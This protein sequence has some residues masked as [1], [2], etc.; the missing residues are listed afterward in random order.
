MARDVG[1]DIYYIATGGKVPLKWTAPEVCILYK[2]IIVRV[3]Y[4]QYITKNF[5]HKVMCGVLDVYCMKY[6]VWA[7]NHLKILMEKR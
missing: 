1:D 6:G 2:Q 4:R 3:S 7:I 5:Q